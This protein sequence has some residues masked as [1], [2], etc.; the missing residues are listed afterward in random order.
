M[1]KI[2]FTV[3]ANRAE[4]QRIQ[5]QLEME[6][7]PSLFPGGP[8][9]AF[10]QLNKEE[11]AAFE[12]K[13]LADYSRKVYKKAHVTKVEIRTQT[14]CQQENSFY[15][16]TVRAFRDRRYEYKA[17]NKVREYSILKDSPRQ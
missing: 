17:L 9:R 16:D 5:Q 4:F 3:P 8:V 15:V 1:Y 14:V 6:K 13:R 10:H 7:F 12:K 11:R 2:C